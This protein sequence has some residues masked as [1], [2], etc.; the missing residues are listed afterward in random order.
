MPNTDLLTLAQ[1]AERAGV[2]QNTVRKLTRD[3]IVTSQCENM[4]SGELVSP[5]APRPK[6][7][8]YLYPPSAVAGIAAAVHDKVISQEV[9]TGGP[10]VVLPQTPNTV[11]LQVTPEELIRLRERIAEE[12]SRADTA[13]A[14]LKRAEGELSDVKHERERLW[15]QVQRLLPPAS[16]G[17][18]TGISQ[19]TEVPVKHRSFWQRLTGRGDNGQAN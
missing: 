5:D 18:N 15:E 12:R 6:R 7:F 1:V 4:E 9:P 8:R 19:A 10:E 2:H 11:T 16:P 14:L 17:P 13:E 3:G